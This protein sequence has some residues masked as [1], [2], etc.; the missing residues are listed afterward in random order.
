MALLLL[1]GDLKDKYPEYVLG[2]RQRGRRRSCAQIIV[3][4]IFPPV[5]SHMPL[6]ALFVGKL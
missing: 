3:E 1:A 6:L 4:K 5:R 2:V